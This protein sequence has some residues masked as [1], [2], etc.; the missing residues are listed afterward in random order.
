MSRAF[1]ESD[2]SKHCLFVCKIA[3]VSFHQAGCEKQPECNQFDLC[4][5]SCCFFSLFETVCQCLEVLVCKCVFV[6]VHVGVAGVHMCVTMIA[7]LHSGKTNTS[8][9]PYIHSRGS[10]INQTAVHLSTHSIFFFFFPPAWDYKVVRLCQE[11]SRCSAK[12]GRAVCVRKYVTLESNGW[13]WEG[14]GR[15]AGNGARARG[16]VGG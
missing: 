16:T 14:E 4:L 8:R 15:W 11:S 6:C 13:G 12:G 2:H 5:F 9:D 3:A 1:I 10:F 7:T